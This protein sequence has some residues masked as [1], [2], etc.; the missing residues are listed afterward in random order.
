MGNGENHLR[1]WSCLG[2]LRPAGKAVSGVVL[3]LQLLSSAIWT[4]PAGP[5]ARIVVGCGGLS[6]AAFHL[7]NTHTRQDLAH[8]KHE[9]LVRLLRGELLLG[10]GMPMTAVVLAALLPL[11][12]PTLAAIAFL[13]LAAA[14]L[15][16]MLQEDIYAIVEEDDDLAHGTTAFG[17]CR[18]LACIGITRSIEEMEQNESS[19]GLL[20]KPLG[21][22]VKPSWRPGLSR[23]RIVIVYAMAILGLIAGGAA[24]GVGFQEYVVHPSAPIE[25]ITKSQNREG[26]SDA[27]H[28]DEGGG[29]VSKTRG[30]GAPCPHLPAFGAPTW[31]RKHL[32][33]LY[34]GGMQLNA[35][36]PPGEIGGCTG[37]AIVPAAQHGRFVY[38]IGRNEF[39]E[40][41]SV[42]VDSFGFGPALFLSPSAKRVLELIRAGHAPLGGYP[43]RNV[44]G[45]D[46]AAAKTEAGTF[47]FVRD[48]KHLP[49]QPN[50]ATPYRRLP[51]AIAR[52]WLAAMTELESW[53]WPLPPIV[54]GELERFRFAGERGATEATVTIAFRPAAG[55]ALWNGVSYGR[56]EGQLN[57]AELERVAKLAR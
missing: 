51:P 20:Q 49:G 35:T 25:T 28:T 39:G 23:T 12:S 18:P 6:I 29:D 50:V 56:S 53:L 44:V 19:P 40:I 8:W 42:A 52:A 3:L 38:T 4:W 46:Y 5:A 32:N 41:L 36:P 7:L 57:Q 14:S 27:D 16:E 11:S 15:Y 30:R 55:T 13:F 17:K 1:A 37:R 48:A 34:Y 45:G 22:W 43:T 21:F 47:V 9:A 54:D 24:G 2:N 26:S 33:A 31:A 10:C